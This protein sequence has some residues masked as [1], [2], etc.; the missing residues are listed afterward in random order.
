MEFSFSG[1]AQNIA[2]SI[3]QVQ[4][5]PLFAQTDGLNFDMVTMPTWPDLPDIG[6]ATPP[7]LLSI[8]PYSENKA[9]AWAV[10]EFL[11]TEE[12]QLNLARV[13]HPPT[14]NRN[15]IVEQ[16]GADTIEATG[17]TFSISPI[18]M[19]DKAVLPPFSK[20]GLIIN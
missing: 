10:T 14:I 20:Y 18:F 7:M 11:S 9:A 4:W 8:N 1:G 3:G 2:M 15:E 5:L 13:G 12:A 6:P 17:Q 19:M 16:F